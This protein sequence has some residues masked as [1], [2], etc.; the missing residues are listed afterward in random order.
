MDE[1]KYITPEVEIITFE[2]KDVIT[3]SGGVSTNPELPL[4]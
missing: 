2:K 4:D 1:R 3:T